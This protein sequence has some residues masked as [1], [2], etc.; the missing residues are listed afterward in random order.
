M[1]IA[2]FLI[3]PPATQYGDF[4]DEPSDKKDIKKYELSNEEA[5]A[6]GNI[7]LKYIDDYCGCLVEPY[8]CDWLDKNKCAL[9]K[10]WI[11]NNKELIAEF[12]L[13]KIFEVLDD[14]CSKAI[15]LDTC[16]VI[17]C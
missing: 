15:E 17:E 9:L 10:E 2:L 8:D 5:Q 11:A 14:F 1:Y 4:P 7:F 6:L 16:I 12:N 13:T 3:K